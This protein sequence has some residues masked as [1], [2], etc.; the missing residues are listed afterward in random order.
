M[1]ITKVPRKRDRHKRRV[2]AYCR[3]STK[4]KNQGE[5]FEEQQNY[6]TNYISVHPEWE[7]AGIYSDEKSGTKATNRP[8]FQ[9]M[10]QDA[11]DGKIDYILVK[12]ISRF[13]RNIVD[14]Q[15][16]ANTLQS[17]GCYIHFEKEGLDTENPSSSMMFAF[18][19]VIAQDES[20]S[21]SDNMKWSYRERY[22][23]GVYNLG[24]NRILGYDSRNGKLIPN[25]D[26][27]TVHLIFQ[28]FTEGKG[29][30]QIAGILKN[31][32]ILGKNKKPLTA[33]GI[34]YI[35]SNEVYTGDRLLQ[36]NAPRNFL[37]KRPDDSIPY[38]SFYLENDHEA[39]VDRKTWNEAQTIF[40]MRR[41]KHQQ[42]TE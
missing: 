29:E 35:L 36:K 5:S 40:Q 16:Y 26:A 11:L 22:K 25:A 37:T 12:S 23:R 38:E 42:T 6:Y 28:L 30:T 18:L 21:I 10:I 15:Q 14:C 41:A 34:R 8:A 2:A 1:K 19:S 27:Q 31:K 4:Q 20:R 39:I 9:R 3:V 24:N 17:Q 32:G 7:F 13:S 33:A